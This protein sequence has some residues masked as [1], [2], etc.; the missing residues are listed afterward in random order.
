MIN[1]R[2]NVS[3][4]LLKNYVWGVLHCMEQRLGPLIGGNWEVNYLESSDVDLMKFV[5]YKL[6]TYVRNESAGKRRRKNNLL[7]YI[8]E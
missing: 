5:E 7:K 2:F 6:N 3:L 1:G 4:R 8:R